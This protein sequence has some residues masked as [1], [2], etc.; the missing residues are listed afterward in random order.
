MRFSVLLILVFAIFRVSFLIAQDK[1]DSLY[2]LLSQEDHPDSLF[3]LH[4]QLFSIQIDSDYQRAK[5]HAERALQLAR[6]LESYQSLGKALE[7]MG[8]WHQYRGNYDSALLFYEEALSVAAQQQDNALAVQM[9]NSIGTVY[10]RKADYDVSVQYFLKSLE[11]AELDGD[12]TSLAGGLNNVG[13]I[14]ELQERYNEALDY[15]Q[16]ALRIKKLLGDSLSY[17][18]T[19]NNIGNVYGELGQ[20]EEAARYLEHSL[21]IKRKSDKAGSLALSLTNLGI[22]YKDL[23]QYEKALLCY[24][25]ALEIDDRL[26]KKEG[27]LSTAN[28][29]AELFIQLNQLDSALHYAEQA[30]TLAE[31]IGAKERLIGVTKTFAKIYE[32]EGK[33]DSAFHYSQRYNELREEVFNEEKSLQISELETRY[34]TEKKELAIEKL[35]QEKQVQSLEIKQAQTQKLIYLLV[36]LLVA[37]LGMVGLYLYRNKIKTNRILSAQNEQLAQLNATKDKLF[38][39]VSHDLK[40]PLSAFRSI[41]ETL[42]QHLASMSP[43]EVQFFIDEIYQSSQQLDDLL[44][45]LLQWASSQT[46][47]LQYEPEVFS[48]S[49]IIEKCIG[50]LQ[51]QAN[52]K[53]IFLQ[54]LVSPE[55]EV[56][57]DPKM[58]Q[59]IVRNLLSNAIKF[60]PD[61][62]NISLTAETAENRVAISV[63]DTGV[64]IAEEDLSALFRVDADIQAVGTSSEK[65]TGIGLIL[66]KELAELNHCAFQV[67]SELGQG[68]TF[69]LLIPAS[70]T[71]KDTKRAEPLSYT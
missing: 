9:N 45:N 28:N 29:L 49:R 30:Y 43:K 23:E 27:M 56:Y 66:C 50:H 6:N 64:G 14:M 7:H 20:N 59:T 2:I 8:A 26:G 58:I 16:Q 52:E 70:Q 19:L 15:Y 18:R 11:A 42:S 68:S 61:G 34:E 37:S 44:R 33:Y 39:I 55:L 5:E 4:S 40:N 54:N 22:A 69:T 53:S 21:R 24:Y 62:G 48:P 65:G 46:G 67:S 47:S 41:T 31:T 1:S 17:A 60:T 57:A 38:A 3:Q 35:E 51:A 10:F 63:I 32:Q 36:L 12:S 13:A 25:E 71:V